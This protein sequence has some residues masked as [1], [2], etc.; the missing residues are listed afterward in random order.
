MQDNQPSAPDDAI[1]SEKPLTPGL[2]MMVDDGLP[3]GTIISLEERKSAWKGKR[4]RPT[5]SMHFGESSKKEEDPATTKLRKEL[6]AADQMKKAARFARLK[7]LKQATQK[8]VAK[9]KE[10]DMTSKA[11]QVKA[12]RVKKATKGKPAKKAPAPKAAAAKAPKKT[13]GIRPGSKLELVVGLLTRK[14]G[15]T[16]ADV[17]AATQWPSV[18]MPQQAKAA[19]LKLRKEKAKGEV[20]RYYGTA[21]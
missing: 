16:T 10:K 19:G 11:D 7:E 20:T 17:L 12:L 3:P 4:P 21:A 9:P 2:K 18:S 5:H 13:E 6:A 15:C 14:E 8:A 1:Q